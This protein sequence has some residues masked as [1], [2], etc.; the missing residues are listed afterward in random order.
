MRHLALPAVLPH[1]VTLPLAATLLNL[2]LVFSPAAL[3]ASDVDEMRQRAKAMRKEAMELTKSGNKEEAERLM[4]E[5]D[6]LLA[7]AEK[8]SRENK[9]H[10]E[11]GPKTD[12]E[13]HIRNIKEQLNDLLG[14]QKKLKQMG[15]AEAEQQELRALISAKESE[16]ARLHDHHAAMSKIHPAFQPQAEKLEATARRIQHLRAAAEH[17]KLAEAHDLAHQ[18]MEKAEGMERELREGKQRLAEQMHSN[19]RREEDSELVRELR[20]ELERLKVEMKELRKR[21]EK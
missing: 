14:R 18:L 15:G 17:L 10:D 2:A 19:H 5:S 4:S 8:I 3:H 21:I 20:S 11:R 6:G 12:R 1:P 16:L 13:I 9:L 7:K